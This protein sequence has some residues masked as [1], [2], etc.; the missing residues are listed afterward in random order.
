MYGGKTPHKQNKTTTTNHVARKTEYQREDLK[1][2]VLK[3]VQVDNAGEL[4]K[5][6]LFQSLL[7]GDLGS[8]SF[9]QPHFRQ[10]PVSFSQQFTCFSRF[11]CF[12]L[13]L[14][15]CPLPIAQNIYSQNIQVEWMARELPPAVIALFPY[16]TPSPQC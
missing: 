9:L 15:S 8:I 11:Y 13:N 6:C 2:G 14:S 1:D 16:D 3:T 5:I 7:Q 10:C 4:C 12:F